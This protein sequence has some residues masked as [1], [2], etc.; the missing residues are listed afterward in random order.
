MRL[1]R[2]SRP[3]LLLVAGLLP[4]P[5]LAATAPDAG[6]TTQEL[7]K[8]LAL[9]AKSPALDLSLPERV[10]T[11]PGGSKVTLWALTFHGN[12]VFTSE[13]LREVLGEVEGK[14]YD[15]AGLKEL[16]DHITSYYHR[17]GYPFAQALVPQQ[18]MGSGNLRIEVIE[19]RYGK[20]SALGNDPRVGQAQG[21]LHRLKPG[22]VIESAPLERA[23]LILN[24]Q[25]GYKTTPV[26]RPGKEVGTGDLD[27]H[28]ERTKRF[29]GDVGLDNYGNRYTGSGRARANLYA[30]SPFM[31]G[32]QVTLSSI[33]TQ[34]NMWYGAL[35]YNAPLGTSGLRGN[36]GY[37]HTYYAL[38]K[39][40]SS[41]DST[42]TADIAS[43]GASYPL[44]RSQKANLNLATTY[45]HK[46]LVD[47]QGAS[48]TR[49]DKQSDSIPVTLGFDRRDGLGGGGVTYGTFGWTHG[50]LKL[51]STLKALDAAT[52]RTDGAFDRFNLDAARLQALPADFTFFAR[53]SGQWA[54]DNLDS[55]E[56]FGLGGPSGV[57]AYPTGEGYGDEGW[58]TQLELRYAISALAP[59]A[60]YDTGSVRIDHDPWTAG[61]N[62]RNVSGAGFGVRTSY[63]GWSADASVAWRTHG[64]APQSDSR[65]RDP[66]FWLNAGYAF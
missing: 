29:G 39:E 17:N 23:T 66:R 34:E 59:Y 56:S 38:G 36:V 9:P 7:K 1:I 40:F 48:S 6:Q 64:G 5:L 42:G 49:S 25:P 16:A 52:A 24:D 54:R 19:G 47:K 45:Q 30:N 13:Q 15:L 57:R 58:L 53:F 12:T 50:M 11:A 21:F 41:L 33:Y 8:P 61:N 44:L 31:L 14:S 65:D 35:G 63:L 3:L 46:W 2:L 51:D 20:I 32:D 10:K 28:V 62:K 4:A 18:D 26:M 60:F 55:S 43:A 22:E 27:V 37:A